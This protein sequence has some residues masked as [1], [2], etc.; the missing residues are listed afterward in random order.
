MAR[1]TS[2]LTGSS[3]LAVD[4][5]PANLDVIVEILEAAG[6]RVSVA[7]TG[8]KAI[9]VASQTKLDLIL[10]DVMMP[11]I[12]GYETCRQLKACEETADVPVI[13]LTARN[14]AQAIR[15]G[16]ESGGEDFVTKPF[17]QEELLARI[18]MSLERVFL[19]REL[20]KLRDKLKIEER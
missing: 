8:E 20:S 11:G 12:D 5:K 13:F 17:G 2:D 10:L 15:Q 6:F 16:F 19:A 18:R 1:A 7:T 3:I 9:Q 4:D 14:D